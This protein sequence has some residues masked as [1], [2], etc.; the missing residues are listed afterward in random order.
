VRLG[1]STRQT[2]DSTVLLVRVRVVA[3]PAA[4]SC[5]CDDLKLPVI[6]RPT[7]IYPSKLLVF[8]KRSFNK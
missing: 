5:V 1:R 2:Q 6:R 4:A 7:K 8:H 3:A